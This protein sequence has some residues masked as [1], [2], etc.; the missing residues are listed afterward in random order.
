MKLLDRPLAHRI[1]T[2]LLLLLPVGARLPISTY[3]NN[4]KGVISRTQTGVDHASKNSTSRSFAIN[5]VGICCHDLDT[6]LKWYGVVL[7]FK[8]V[9][10][11]YIA[12]L[13]LYQAVI[14]TNPGGAMVELQKHSNST[15][16]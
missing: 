15:S 9:V 3:S 2:I 1:Y 14:L 16:L 7:G 10:L 13:P 4:A 12:L 5:H 6:Q 8:K 11:N